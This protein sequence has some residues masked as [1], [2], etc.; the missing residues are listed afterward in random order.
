MKRG[1]FLTGLALLVVNDWL[2]KG[3]GW[4]PGWF[5]GKLSDAA[6]LVV[7]PVVLATV[8]ALARVPSAVARGLAVAFVAVVFAAIKVDAGFAA[9]FDAIVNAVVGGLR[10]P[11][12]ARTIADRTDLV[13][14]PLVAVGGWL[15][16]HLAHDRPLRRSGALFAGLLACAATSPS[17]M[18]L[19]PHWAF[20]RQPAGRIWG[21]PVPSG[22]VVVQM[23][24]R[25][26]DG[27]FEVGVEIAAR[28]GELTFDP[29]SLILDLPGARVAAEAPD[30]ALASVRVPPGTTASLRYVFRP[31]AMTWPKGTAGALE[32]T[33]TDGSR[34]VTLR[35]DLTFDE[36]IVPWRDEPGLR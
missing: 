21:A 15:A 1:V 17:Q 18:K 13:A 32:L 14:L 36:R 3:A 12:A 9:G 8:F 22:A 10:L 16:G 29:R 27:A 7:A 4:L 25:S 2:L 11:L 30:G 19:E 24:R 5:T 20:A 26:S 6:G 23:G 34:P 35:A 33:I 31:P 28:T